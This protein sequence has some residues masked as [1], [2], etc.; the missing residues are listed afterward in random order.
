MNNLTWCANVNRTS[1]FNLGM[2]IGEDGSCVVEV[3]VI[4]YSNKWIPHLGSVNPLIQEV[5]LEVR[6][7]FEAK[8]TFFVNQ[9]GCI[10]RRL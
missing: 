3:V 10:A 6:N 1:V 9:V 5:F 4:L 2:M 8:R 7:T